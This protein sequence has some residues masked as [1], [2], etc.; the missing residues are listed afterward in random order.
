MIRI[1]DAFCLCYIQ[2]NFHE[3]VLKTFVCSKV[4]F[5]ICSSRILYLAAAVCCVLR[6]LER[7][8]VYA[9]TME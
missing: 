2:L 6:A 8:K 3:A 5:S 9:E 7:A 4:N 1:A